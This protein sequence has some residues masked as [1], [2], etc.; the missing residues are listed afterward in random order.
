ML[1]MRR[2]WLAHFLYVFLVCIFCAF[3]GYALES[4]E[5]VIYW[6]VEDLE[7]NEFW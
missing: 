2:L 4:G 7:L 1:K 5:S 6:G 3:F